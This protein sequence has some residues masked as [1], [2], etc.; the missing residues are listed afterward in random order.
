[1]GDAR[2]GT[3]WSLE[4]GSAGTYVVVNSVDDLHRLATRAGDAGAT[5]IAPIHESPP[6]HFQLTLADIEGN[7]WAFGTYPGTAP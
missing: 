6:G 1:V 7:L 2:E 4:P 3:A 5:P